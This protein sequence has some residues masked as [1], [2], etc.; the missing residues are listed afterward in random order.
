VRAPPWFARL[1]EPATAL[2]SG[3]AGGL[4]FTWLGVPLGWLLGAMFATAAA[5]FSGIA[6]GVPP[7]LRSTVIAILGLLIGGRFEPGRFAAIGQWLPSVGLLVVYVLLVG[8]ISLVYLRRFARLGPHTAFFAATPGGLS[9]M[10]VLSD[11]MGA[12]MRSVALVHASRVLLIVTFA[13]ILVE[14]LGGAP[15]PAVPAGT[16]ELRDLPILA[17]AGVTGAVVARRLALPAPELMGPMLLS[18]VLHLSEAVTAQVPR[19]MVIFAQVTIGAAIGSRFRGLGARRA[20]LQLL[21]GLGLTLLMFAITALFALVLHW[22]TG[23]PFVALV[24]A[25]V[26][27]GVVEMGT[28]SLALGVDPAFVTAHHLI[29]ITLVVFLA[30]VLFPFW[31]R[32]VERRREKEHRP[33]EAVSRS[34]T[35]RR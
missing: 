29:R 35:G 16:P 4:L 28:I 3:C 8:A 24:L 7:L 5:T 10:V 33:E 2:A 6:A 25:Y 17:L 34:R 12:D 9:E 11:R 31:R 21:A 27:G 32:F 30:P 18:A 14:L 13:P 1:R 26:P 22:Y 15:R 23:L 20:L 19:E